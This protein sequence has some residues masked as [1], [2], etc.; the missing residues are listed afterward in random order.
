M[1]INTVG[2][3]GVDSNAQGLANVNY[4]NNTA[5]YGSYG[6]QLQWVKLDWLS[7]DRC[8]WGRQLTTAIF[9]GLGCE[10]GK[11]ALFDFYSILD[12]S[13]HNF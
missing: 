8:S 5:T 1:V 10:A 2:H 4:E 9:V 13:S 12:Q 3:S 7:V 11:C 6:L